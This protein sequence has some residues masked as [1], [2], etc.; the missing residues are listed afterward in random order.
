MKYRKLLAGAMICLISTVG[1][2]GRAEALLWKGFSELCFE[3]EWNGGSVKEGNL[4]VTVKNVEMQVQCY[5]T[6][7]GESCQPGGG[8]AGNLTVTVPASADPTKER[9]IIS[10]NGCISLDKFDHHDYK[11]PLDPLDTHQHMCLPSSNVNKIEVE[12]S[13]YITKIDVEYFLTSKDGQNIQR[14]GIQ[15][16]YWDGTFNSNT[17]EPEHAPEFGSNFTCPIDEEFRK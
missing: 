16:C 9:G 1:L 8:N 13:A 3:G 7:A 5:N 2:V 12:N 4:T 6:S 14:R 10:A 17:C 11:N 15:T